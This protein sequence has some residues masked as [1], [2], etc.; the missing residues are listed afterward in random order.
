MSESGGN[1]HSSSAASLTATMLDEEAARLAAQA[2]KDEQILFADDML[3]GVGS[4][5]MTLSE[6][7]AKG[8]IRTFMVLLILNSLDE[9]EGATM[10][11]LAPDIRDSF[12]V[13]DGVITFI[14]SASFAF[15]VLGAMP[16]GWLADR[17]RRPPI[18]GS[19]SLVFGAMVFMSGLAVNAFMLFWARFGVGVAK[20]NT[21]PVHGSLIADTYPIGVRGR[22]NATN[23]M[24]GRF[25]GAASPALAGT[26]AFVFGDDGWRYAFLI[27]GLPVSAFA[28]FAF[29]L[30]EPPRG[31]WEKDDVVG[32]VLDD[33]EPAPV[34]VEAA[35]ARLWK[36]NTLRSVIVAF[37]AMGF[38]LFTGAVLANLF[39]EDEFGLS[40]LQ[41]GWLATATAIPGILA[42]PFVGRYFDG[43]YRKTPSRA[44]ATLGL[45]LLPSTLL[46]PAQYYLAPNMF[47][48]TALVLPTGYEVPGSVL[49]FGVFNAFNA[50]LVGASFAMVPALLQAVVPYRLRG[51]GSAMATMYIFFIGAVGG[52][53]IAAW[54]SDTWSPR[55]AAMLAVPAMLIGGL[56]VVRSSRFIR[57]DLSLVVAE[58]QEEQEEHERQRTDP[59]S[60][61]TI[62]V[63]NIDFSYGNVQVLFDVD[64]EVRPGEVLALLGTNGAG[65]S[66]ILRVISGLS[67]PERG[68]VRLN[69]RNITFASP[70]QRNRMGVHLLL[71]GKGVFDTMTIRQNLVMA[72]FP[73]RKDKA[74]VEARLER[75]YDLFPDLRQRQA[76][77]AG[78]LSGGQQQMLALA[79]T[80]LHDPEVL[81][82]DELS[83][84]LAPIVVEELLGVVERLKAEDLTIIIVE[85]SLNVALAIADRAVFLEK[86]RVRFEG[87]A[88]ELLERDDLARAVFLGD[89]GG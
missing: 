1:R 62:Q 11:V 35:F 37:S 28:I 89:E 84:G 55:F 70:E 76:Q 19:A 83:L 23:S 46:V 75:V 40:S 72:A 67:T 80:M 79:A 59:D 36:I 13:S 3:P 5:E 86:G 2:D 20:S 68:V 82:I 26:I 87:D 21:I 16:M 56:T 18:I 53:L 60:V 65:K 22:I 17:F 63:N 47:E 33:A 52:G 12:G 29:F 24:V 8:G 14:V 69:G 45:L 32:E 74:E 42:V 4:A 9:L 73:Y 25:I 66:T 88:Q 10:S 77:K 64:F 30:K 54:A 38:S 58:L 50:L 39:L 31:Q 78:S 61:P 43:L 6:G 51:L 34:S 57:N 85:Q 15:V 48:N 41:R 71:G 7:L 49:M 81:I 44:L 27:L